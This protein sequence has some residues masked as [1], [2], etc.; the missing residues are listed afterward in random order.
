MEEKGKKKLKKEKERKN[1]IFLIIGKKIKTQTKKRRVTFEQKV[2]NKVVPEGKIIKGLAVYFTYFV[3][4]HT[5]CMCMLQ[6][7]QWILIAPI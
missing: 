6:T 4:R 7:L 1:K 3:P 2:K 5:N